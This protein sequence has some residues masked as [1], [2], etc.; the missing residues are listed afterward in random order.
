MIK[1]NDG[2]INWL[3]SGELIIRKFKAYSQWPGLYT[4]WNNKRLIIKEAEFQ[5][6]ENIISK[7]NGQILELNNQGI[8]VKTIDGLIYIKSLQLEGGKIMDASLFVNGRPS[9]LSSN[10]N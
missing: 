7:K 3:D 10:L 6:K 1:K 2:L 5:K 9:F 4:H 8:A